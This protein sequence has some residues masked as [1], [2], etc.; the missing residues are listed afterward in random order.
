M[1][2]VDLSKPKNCLECPARMDCGEY[3][4]WLMDPKNLYDMPVVLSSK[5]LIKEEK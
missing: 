2:V 1:I 5:C 4:K 3:K